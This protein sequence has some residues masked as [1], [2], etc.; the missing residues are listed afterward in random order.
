[1]A[2]CVK[3]RLTG[4]THILWYLSVCSTLSKAYLKSTE[5]AQ[6]A[7]SGSIILAS[8]NGTPTIVAGSYSLQ[9]HK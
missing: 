2:N 6:P 3:N 7:F 5:E 4:L 8:I 1:M 9:E